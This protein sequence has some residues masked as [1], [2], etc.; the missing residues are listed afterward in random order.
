[1]MKSY[2]WIT[3]NTHISFNSSLSYLHINV[4]TESP[5]LAH[6]M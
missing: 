3:P 1:M 5:Q 4:F 2:G 6:Y